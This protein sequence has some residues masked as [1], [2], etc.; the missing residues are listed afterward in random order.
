MRFRF[1]YGSHVLRKCQKCLNMLWFRNDVIYRYISGWI[2]V[3]EFNILSMRNLAQPSEIRPFQFF[4]KS[5]HFHFEVNLLMHALGRL[6]ILYEESSTDQ[7]G[8]VHTLLLSSCSSLSL[9]VCIFFR[10][11]LI[12]CPW[13]LSAEHIYFEF[14]ESTKSILNYVRLKIATSL[15]VS[16]HFVLY[17]FIS[18][19][20][21]VN[22]LWSL[23]F[24][25]S[26]CVCLQ[27]NLD[28]SY[29]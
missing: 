10:F 11:H 2:H 18:S 15:F 28:P 4:G 9:L 14:Q 20:S 24:S 5:I 7:S 19:E 22:M 16:I 1:Q 25:L 3:F 21:N 13:N 17:R 27:V 23:S 6:P 26:V 12:I 29:H 8:F